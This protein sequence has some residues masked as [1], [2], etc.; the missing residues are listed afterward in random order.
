L[1]AL[2][3]T[4][5]PP[6]IATNLSEAEQ[7]MKDMFAGEYGPFWPEASPLV[8]E[9]DKLVAAICT[10]LKAPWERTP[11]CPFIVDLMVHPDF[12]RKGLAAFLLQ[13][14]ARTALRAG[15][16]HVALRVLLDNT[17]AISLYRKLG[18][19]DWDKRLLAPE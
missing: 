11:T 15:H 4:A 10:V 2:W 14:T 18:F 6:E 3:F 13:E 16:T 12:R 5:Y 19:E 17:P 9:G 8:C 7:E 1:A